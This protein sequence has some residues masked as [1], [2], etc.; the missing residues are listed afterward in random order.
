MPRVQ[1]RILHHRLAPMTSHMLGIQMRRHSL[2]AIARV[3]R[4]LGVDAEVVIFGHVHRLGPLAGED[5][6]PW[7]GPGGAP[8]LIN[9]GSWR[10]ESV[11]LHHARPPHPYW[12]GGAVVV[13]DGAEPRAIG[14]L[15]GLAADQL[16]VRRVG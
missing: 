6:E 5:P 1:R 2:P 10:Y 8:R 13:E 15:D 12:P 14:L 3:A 7:R 9:T 11:L 4:E 16:H